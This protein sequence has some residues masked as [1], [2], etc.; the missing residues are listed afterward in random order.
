M[1]KR[2]DGGIT[3]AILTIREALFCIV[4]YTGQADSELMG[5][6]LTVAGQV[7]MAAHLA[8]SSLG[9]DKEEEGDN[10][11]GEFRRHWVRRKKL[12]PMVKP[13][14]EGSQEEII[15][16]ASL[17]YLQAAKVVPSPNLKTFEVAVR[18]LGSSYAMLG[19]HYL[20]TG[21]FT[22]ARRHHTQGIVLFRSPR[23]TEKVGRLLSASVARQRVGLVEALHECTHGIPGIIELATQPNGLERLIMSIDI[24]Q[25]AR[26]ELVEAETEPELW[27]QILLLLGRAHSRYGTLVHRRHAADTGIAHTQDEHD[28]VVEHLQGAIAAFQQIETPAFLEVAHV[29]HMLGSHYARC[30]LYSSEKKTAEGVK[31]RSMHSLALKAFDKA[32][33][34]MI[35]HMGSP[36]ALL[37]VVVDEARYLNASPMG[38]RASNLETA[39]ST[40][41]RVGIVMEEWS[42]LTDGDDAVD[43][44]KVEDEKD[45]SYVQIFSE[46]HASLK[47][48]ISAQNKGGKREKKVKDLK[49][50][51]FKTLTKREGSRGDTLRSIQKALVTMQLS[52]S[53]QSAATGVEL[54]PPG[55]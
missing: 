52:S 54:V 49:A 25:E 38:Q 10:G 35:F 34:L 32:R 48:A 37:Q 50:L 5:G 46:I 4:N 6:M 7:Y 15:Q 53:D 28:A 33:E 27:S 19:K 51:Y 21:R 1:C 44:V 23:A 2:G 29:N 47:A 40:L 26:S 12:H 9:W 31:L 13:L 24:L 22:K 18:G 41:L 55:M 45:A 43:E 30:V 14:S 11:K 20:M 17:C 36:K 16:R 42:P 8:G 39:M 3:E